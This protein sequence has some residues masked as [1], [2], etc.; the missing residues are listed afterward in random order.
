MTTF[1]HI[2]A[3]EGVRAQRQAREAEYWRQ[4]WAQQL[5]K[6]KAQSPVAQPGESKDSVSEVAA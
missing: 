5:A 2:T 6:A 1:E 4:Y 3:A